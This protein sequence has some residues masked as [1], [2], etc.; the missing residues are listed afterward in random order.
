[1]ST[2]ETHEQHKK[3]KHGHE[4]G[5]H[6]H[7]HHKHEHHKHEH[8]HGEKHEHG[9]GHGHHEHDYPIHHGHGACRTVLTLR[10][11]SGLSG[12]MMLAGLAT[13]AHVDNAGLRTLTAELRL[14]ELDNCVQL[15]QRFVNSVAGWGCIVTLPH[16]HAHRTLA[17]IRTLLE[18]SALP[19]EARALAVRTFEL[20]AEAEGAVHGKSREDVTFH[21]VGALDSIL[22]IALVCRLFTM[23]APAALVC[24]PLP[25]AD[26]SI[27]CAHGHMPSPAPAVLRLLEHVPVY[28]FAGTGE[29]VTPTALALLKALGAHFGGWP[30]MTIK[31]TTISYGTKIFEH[32]PNGAVWALGE[33]THRDK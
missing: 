13:L 1:M 7:E 20:L 30:A 16:E 31:A 3:E 14:P 26:G 10:P 25:V 5:H 33:K 12:D 8:Q 4:H 32:A 19:D 21:E 24:G 29:T 6:E 2:K 15:E 23:L 9:H 17:D 28:S 18:A 11:Y 27:S 22:D